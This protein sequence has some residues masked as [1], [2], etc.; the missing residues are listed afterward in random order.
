MSEGLYALFWGIVTFSLLV[1][2]HEG[3]HFLAARLF[4]VKVHEFMIGLPGPAIRLRGK[5]T[6]YGVTAI[7]LGGYVRIAGMEPGPEDPLLEPALA[8]VT[9]RGPLTAEGLAGE[10]GV[11]DDEADALLVTLADWGALEATERRGEVYR[12]TFDPDSASDSAE[13]IAA[14]RSV[15]YRG[16]GT[17]KRVAVL[18]MGVL[19][20]LLT[21]VL[22]FTVVLSTFGYSEYT[23]AVGGVAPDSGAARAGIREGDRIVSFDG[24]ALESYDELLSTVRNSTVGETVD[25]VV[26]R[27]GE[28]LTL[29]ATLGRNPETGKAMLG[30]QPG[31]RTFSAEDVS[32]LKAFGMS[33]SYIWLTFVAIA[34]FFNPET[35]TQSVE[36]SSSVIGASIYAAEAAKSGPLDYARIIA[37]LSL[38]LGVINIL[39][40]PPLDGGKIAVE[41]I[42]RLR[43]RPLP[44]NFSIAVSL[45]GAVLLFA[46]VGYLMY[47]DVVR[48]AGG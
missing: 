34:G 24:V 17:A 8:A 11:S 48:L 2:V 9:A 3:G 37:I 28:R 19:F 42:E 43:G 20:N 35:F 4:G 29:V 46:L 14:A 21:A 31:F 45:T 1:V 23:D 33:F 27:G 12:S 40:I 13:L 41:L 32:A 16:L 18:S 15:T 22:V 10:L 26:V 36:Q 30:V 5:K 7:P 38:S 44:R 39:P 25:V 6:T 47:E